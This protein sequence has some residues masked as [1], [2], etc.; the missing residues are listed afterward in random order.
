MANYFVNNRQLIEELSINTGTSANPVY[1]P[2]CVSSDIGLNTDIEEQDFYVFCDA[3]KRYVTTGADVGFNATVK[4][5]IQSLAVQEVLSKVHSLIKDGTVNQFS[6]VMIKFALLSG[7]SND[8]LEY[9]TYTATANM[10][11]SDLGGSAEEVSEFTVEFKLNGKA[12]ESG[13]SM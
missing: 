6:N 12:T 9:T 2:L 11:V 13:T 10:M 5:D 8:T 4:L 3:L 1:S 7:I